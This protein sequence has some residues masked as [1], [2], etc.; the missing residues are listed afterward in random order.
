MALLNEAQAAD[1]ELSA[2]LSAELDKFDGPGEST[3]PEPVAAEPVKAAPAEPT[4]TAE[5]TAERVRD[6]KGRFAAKAAETSA[7]LSAKAPAAAAVPTT[8]PEAAAGQPVAVAAADLT[9]MRPPPG[10][11]PA[12]KVAFDAL[13]AEVKSAVAQREVEINKGFAKLAE[14][15]PIERFADMARQSGTT[16]DRALESYV[17]IEN[18]LRRD[19]IGG[20]AQICQRQGVNPLALA[21]TILARAG[22]ATDQPVA[23]GAAQVAPQTAPGVDLSPVMQKINALETYIQQQQTSGVQ[24]EIE[25][26]ASDPKHTFF[27]NVKTEMGR[28]IKA[29]AADSLADAYDKACWSNAE[30]RALLIKQQSA[31]DPSVRAAA[32]N[33]ARQSAKSITGSPT[34]GAKSGSPET[35]IEDELRSLWD[36][37]V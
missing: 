2:M 18:E 28:L 27:D 34:P 20:I 14:Y 36:A 5:Q 6:E 23:P 29:G 24:S 35:S 10:W 15:K 37:T 4:E 16:L 11:S 13:P 9:A 33:Q 8:A 26:F 3:T 30:I 31:A 32:A 21:Q 25:R 12:A 1:D 17:G 7:E 22:M 19:F